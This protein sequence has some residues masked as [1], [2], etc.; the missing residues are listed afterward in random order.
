MS[1]WE[2]VKRIRAR[3][4][5]FKT[6]VYPFLME[7]LE[8][9]LRKIGKRR[10]VSAGELLDGLCGYAKDRYGLLAHDI[11]RS[12]GILG[13]FDIGLAVFHLVE[14]GVLSRQEGDRL[15]DFDVDYDLRR[16]LEEEYFAD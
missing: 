13:A 8:Y 7:S 2:A 12:W 11:L 5:R 6:D 16:K 1:F 14:A 3:D 9:T 15:E 4:D 10:H